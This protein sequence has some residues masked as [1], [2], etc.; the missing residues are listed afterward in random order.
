MT[1]NK[2]TYPIFALLFYCFA[3]VFPTHA[4]QKAENDSNIIKGSLLIVPFATYQEETSFAPGVSFACHFKSNDYGRISSL[5]GFAT[6]TFR[7]Q[8][9]FQ[10][11]PKIYF[12]DTKWFLYGHLSLRNYTDRFYG[13]GNQPTDLKQPYV[14]QTFGID[15][16]P[17][18][19]TG[20]DLFVGPNICYEYEKI[21]PGES[22]SENRDVIF[23]NYG[24]TGWE[25]P[26]GRLALG[27]AGMY[28]KRDNTFYTRKGYFAKLV[29]NVAVAGIGSTYTTHRLTADYRHFL[30]V[31]NSHTLAWQACIN[32]V[33]GKEIPFSSLP[34]V[35]GS[36]FLRGFRQGVYRD[37]C[38]FVL[39]AEYRMPVYK[40]FKSVIFLSAGDVLNSGNAHIEKLK[41]SYGVG[42]RFRY[43][44]AGAHLRFDVAK[45]NYGDDFQFYL[46]ASEAF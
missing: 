6:Y 2:Y 23:D 26:Y 8:F 10:A 4:Q 16:Q 38:M 40:R 19:E 46:T 13:I 29:Y 41:V 17:Q 36:D 7:H 1:D 32:V 28:N 9:V 24:K 42:L 34:T 14:A 39:Q 20:K 21:E 11:S 35:G 43:N 31:F 33:W 44:D 30:P 37:N 15:L 12:R 3:G 27:L 22:F 45:N 5:N 18:Y 25:K